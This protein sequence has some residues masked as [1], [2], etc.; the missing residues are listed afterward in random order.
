MNY[1]N[2]NESIWSC[3][4]LEEDYNQKSFKKITP[5]RK[6]VKA[7]P[8]SGNGKKLSS[9]HKD[10]KKIREEKRKIS[11]QKVKRNFRSKDQPE[12]SFFEASISISRGYPFLR[13]VKIGERAFTFEGVNKPC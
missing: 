12:I 8:I 1:D 10:I 7:K 3:S 5:K 9:F 11:T 4:S 6:I 13:L 2:D